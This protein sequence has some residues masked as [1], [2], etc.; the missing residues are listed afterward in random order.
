MT[1]NRISILGLL[2]G[3]YCLA[4]LGS[5]VAQPK[6]GRT[7]D[8]QI[9]VTA[10]K[11]S[12]GESG[13]QVEASGNV[14]IK[15]QGTTLRAEDVKVN[16]ATQD[17]EASGNV[18]VDDPEWK[19]KSAESIQMNLEKETGDLRKADL[20]LEQ[21]HISM[22]GERFQKLGG[23]TYHVDEG[24]FTTCLCESGTPPWKFFAEQMDL[25]LDGLGVIRNGY[26]YV[27]DVPVFYIPYGFFPLR[28]E[29][30]TGLLFPKFGHSTTE[31][32]R[33]QQPFFWA[34]S[35]STDATMAFDVETRARYGFLGEVR[36]MFDRRSDFRLD[37]AYFNEGAR[38]GEEQAIVDRTIADQNIP[39]NRWS[40]IGTHRY[41]LPAD[42]LTFSDFA[43]YR[44]D[45]FTR[46]LIERFDLP[47]SEE[48]DIR[49]SRYSSSRFGFF[50]SWGDSHFRGQWNF[51]QDFIQPD[52]TTLHRTP[53]ASF[54][55]RRAFDAFP[56]ELRWQAQGVNYIRR[57]GGDGLRFDLRP[58]FT[59]PFRVSS[60]LFGSAS[61]APRETVYHLYQAV[62]AGDRNVSRETIELRGNIATSIN[63][64]FQV[65]SLGIVGIKHVIEP[66]LSYLFV[67]HT[68]QSRIPIMD[69]VDRMNRRNVLTF[70]VTNRF[71]G[72]FVGPLV[73]LT[74]DPDVEPLNVSVGGDVRRMVSL[75][76]A[77]SYDIDRERKKGDTL[78][79]VD[80]RLRLTPTNYLSFD[81]DG[82]IDPGRWDISQARAS[83][84]ISDPRPLTRRV[85]DPDF[86]R[87]NSINVGY[88]F[89]RR[90]VNGFLADDANVDC[91][92][93]PLNPRCPSIVDKNIVGNV[94]LNLF[95]R[96]TDNLVTNVNSTYDARDN[97]FIGVRAA[98]K[99]LSSCECWTVTFAARRDINPAKTSFNFDFSLLGLGSQRSTLK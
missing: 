83:F 18:S 75:R 7:G 50:K 95:Y 3:C 76:L 77:L 6:Q 62:I 32:F 82:G 37:G 23:Q 36:T 39:V 8:D 96:L 49:R 52:A 48:S 73:D 72:K 15:R 35:K 74:P 91:I 28:T 12:I 94:V 4:N 53:E 70:A 58:E 2:L 98:T 99:L 51:Y 14:E 89:L 47:G 43:V 60:Y 13:T 26:F 30:Q 78:S 38:K 56:I 55:G 85:L 93:D 61:V 9:N 63:R 68:D 16:R 80:I 19:V 27:F 29:R 59:L 20:F 42:W 11:L 44:D 84:S 65:R 64:I 33:Y 57:E 22:S 90:G 67:P 81:L 87:A 17:V 92:A 5:A 25:R 31:G 10:D 71:W 69:D 46:E 45:L 54:W 86:N 40:A 41:T 21:G 97:R 88:Q 24:F 79:D 1:V 34:I 66:E